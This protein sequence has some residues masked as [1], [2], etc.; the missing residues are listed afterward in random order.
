MSM[1]KKRA[2]NQSKLVFGDGVDG[3]VL[4]WN[5]CYVAT[6]YSCFELQTP[7]ISISFPISIYYLFIRLSVL[8]ATSAHAKNIEIYIFFPSLHECRYHKNEEGKSRKKTW[9]CERKFVRKTFNCPSINFDVKACRLHW[10]WNFEL[11]S[12][13]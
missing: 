4:H 6:F 2:H 11:E 3:W 7:F 8:L 10:K 5:N 12:S 9:L 13:S 1:K